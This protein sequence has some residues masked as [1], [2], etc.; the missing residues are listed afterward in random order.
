MEKFQIR[1]LKENKMK[2]Q[3]KIQMFALQFEPPFANRLQIELKD[4][5]NKNGKEHLVH[6]DKSRNVNVLAIADLQPIV[7]YAT[8]ETVSTFQNHKLR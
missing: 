2:I 4:Y 3:K 1:F 7:F 8:V 6:I 5:L